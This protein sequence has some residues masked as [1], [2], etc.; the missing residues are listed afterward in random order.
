MSYFAQP[1][2][3]RDQFVLIPTTLEDTIP[4]DHEVRLL[5]DILQTQDWSSWEAEYS[6]RRG[7][8]PIPP[9]VVASVILYGLLRRVRSSR[10]LEYMTGHNVDFIWLTEG[11]TIDHTTLCK[12]RTRFKKPL[13]ELF[14]GLN[15]MA[16]AMG[17]I[18]LG[19]VTFDGTRV[20]ANNGRHEIWTAAAVEK[21]LA[22]LAAECDQLMAKA[23]Q[24]DAVED[25]RFG[26]TA[27]VGGSAATA[28][29]RCGPTPRRN[30]HGEESRPA[31]LHRHRFDNAAEQGRGLRP[32]LHS[33]GR[34]RRPR[35][36][37]C[38]RGSSPQRQ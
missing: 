27:S 34:G 30:R 2:L 38:R 35:G 20:K 1:T 22:E 11:R 17:L 13:K 18:R 24:T 36:F 14:V 3:G 8:P 6:L 10:V 9:R 33:H 29:S 7:Q 23:E 37:H 32:Q 15:R 19:E 5:D 4:D 31:P 21:R 26:L 28:R 12:F 16:M 25:E